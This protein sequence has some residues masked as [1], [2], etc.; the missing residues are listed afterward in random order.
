MSYHNLHLL[1][2]RRTPESNISKENNESGSDHNHNISNNPNKQHMLPSS[3]SSTTLLTSI[4]NRNQQQYKPSK[5]LNR[6]D[7]T[8]HSRIWFLTNCCRSTPIQQQEKIDKR[9]SST[10]SSRVT[11]SNTILV[12]YCTYHDVAVSR[13]TCV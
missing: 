8:K 3:A 11:A 6:K 12:D 5:R 9:S 7:K 4:Q 13:V 10:T 1:R 2:Y